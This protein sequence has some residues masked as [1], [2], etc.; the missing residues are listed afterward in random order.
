M[1]IVSP[2]PVPAT[3]L[4]VMLLNPYASW[5]SVG[6][7]GAEG[8]PPAKGLTWNVVWADSDAVLS[9]ARGSRS[10]ILGFKQRSVEERQRRDLCVVLELIGESPGWCNGGVASRR[11]IQREDRHVSRRA[12]PPKHEGAAESS[13]FLR[14]AGS[15]GCLSHRRFGW[16]G[17]QASQQHLATHSARPDLRRGQGPSVATDTLA[18]DPGRAWTL[19]RSPLEQ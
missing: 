3:P 18:H 16:L 12:G 1:A 5:S 19:G 2:L 17:G 15:N 10:S 11:P 4:K 6:V 13:G 9:S 14:A 7:Y 8:P